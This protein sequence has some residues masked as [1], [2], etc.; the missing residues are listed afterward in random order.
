[1]CLCVYIYVCVFKMKRKNNKIVKELTFVTSL[2]CT[3]NTEK[4]L[5]RKIKTDI[6]RK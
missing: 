4:S 2:L 6:K 1:M 5:C 3:I